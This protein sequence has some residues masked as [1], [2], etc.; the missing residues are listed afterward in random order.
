MLSALI[1]TSPPCDP[2]TEST[3]QS[4]SKS[5]Q[6]K[7]NNAFRPTPQRKSSKPPS[8]TLIVAPA[9]LLSQWSEEIQRSSKP[10]TIKALI[11]HGQ[12]RLDLEA[13]IEDDSDD[14]KSIKVIIT[15][16]GVLASEHAKSERS[17]SPVFESELKTYDVW[18][19]LLILDYTS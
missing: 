6:L 9:S 14:D 15:S 17:K 3:A 2:Q 7:L 4:T 12:N 5:R 19:I 16:Y 1:Q 11:W 13:A 18:L 10:G 8:V